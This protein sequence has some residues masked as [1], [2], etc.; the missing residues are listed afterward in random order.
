[1]AE[2]DC[3]SLV[4]LI[5][6]TVAL[7]TVNPRSDPAALIA[8]QPQ[9]TFKITKT[10]KPGTRRAQPLPHLWPQPSTVSVK[11]MRCL[12]CGVAFW[13]RRAERS[14]EPHK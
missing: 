13:E 1:M 6:A 11:H 14:C 5:G 8:G 3:L 4:R 12:N 10:A 7:N 2:N 9:A